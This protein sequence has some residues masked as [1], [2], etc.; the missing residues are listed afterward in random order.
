M[1]KRNF[2]RTE[3]KIRKI[4]LMLNGAKKTT[5]DIARISTQEVTFQISNSDNFISSNLPPHNFRHEV[6]VFDILFTSLSSNTQSS[7]FPSIRLTHTHAVVSKNVFF[8]APPPFFFFS[9]CK[10]KLLIQSFL[11][12][13]KYF[14]N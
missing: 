4:E 14:I 6:D 1:E 9:P 12:L 5:F 13:M 8:Y 11:F 3:I 7:H 10:Q 2:S